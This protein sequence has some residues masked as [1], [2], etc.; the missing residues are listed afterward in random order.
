MADLGV[1]VQE[2]VGTDESVGPSKPPKKKQE[3]TPVVPK[4][5]E[6]EKDR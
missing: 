3:P 1:Q 4:K 6:D 5:R 2:T